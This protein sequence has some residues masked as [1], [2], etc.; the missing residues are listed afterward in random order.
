T[1]S[2]CESG[3]VPSRAEFE[4]PEG[5]KLVWETGEFDLKADPDAARPAVPSRDAQMSQYGVP[6]PDP[7]LTSNELGLL[8]KGAKTGS[9]KVYNPTNQL[10]W[11][12]L[13]GAPVA[14]LAPNRAWSSSVVSQG[15]YVARLIDF[16]GVETAS[17]PGFTVD[18]S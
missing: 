17:Q 5:G 14:R 3:L 10:Q 9:L 13:D 7:V 1:S 2:L 6:V 12:L 15:T 16:F 8:R 18:E 4:S 11:L